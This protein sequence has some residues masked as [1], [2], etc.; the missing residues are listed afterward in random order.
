METNNPFPNCFAAN[1][2]GCGGVIAGGLH[3]KG[4]QA[5]SAPSPLPSS[6]HPVEPALWLSP[7]S[8]V[9]GHLL[10]SRRACVPSSLRPVKPALW[11]RPSSR[12]RGRLR[13]GEHMIPQ[14]SRRMLVFMVQQVAARFTEP[15]WFPEPRRAPY[16]WEC[17]GPVSRVEMK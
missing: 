7:S 16:T 1:A 3:P 11:L 4:R 14:G 5:G 17:F 10:P 12:V 13:S 6:L 8:R 2:D 15:T 9:R